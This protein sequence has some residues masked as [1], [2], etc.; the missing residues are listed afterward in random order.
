MSLNAFILNSNV[1]PLLSFPPYDLLPDPPANLLPPL[2]PFCLCL[3]SACPSAS[4]SWI[5]HNAKL[6]PSSPS[7]K[8]ENVEKGRHLERMEWWSSSKAR[9]LQHPWTELPTFLGSKEDFEVTSILIL[10]FFLVWKVRLVGI[11]VCHCALL[12]FVCKW[13]MDNASC[14]YVLA[15]VMSE[16]CFMC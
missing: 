5:F 16:W 13:S 8:F 10:S 4:F 12:Y 3:F 11:T 2:L 6:Q 1:T 9:F 7:V 15:L 14:I